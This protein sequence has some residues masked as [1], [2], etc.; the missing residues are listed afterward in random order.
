MT[1]RWLGSGLFLATLATLLLETLD[2]RLLSVL[3]WYHLSF[4]AVSLAM[5]GMA[6]GAVFVFLHPALFSTDRAPVTVAR[7]AFWF[8]ASIPASHLATLAIPFLPLSSVSVM[9]VLSV[10]VATLV[11]AVPFALSGVLVTAALTR[12]GGRIGRLYALDLVGAALGC[13][14]VI[15]LLELSNIS[16]A[17]LMAGAAAA[18]SAF[19]LAR[20][21]RVPGRLQSAVLLV[22]LATVSVVN[23]SAHPFIEVLY[24]KNQQLWLTNK[25]N[26]ITAWNSHSYVLVQGPGEQKPFLWGPGVGGDRFR[27][28]LAWLVIDGEAG[29]P[30]TEWDGRPESLEW[31]SYD[32]TT[33]PYFLRRGDV[34]VIGV[35][36]GRDILAALWGRNTSILGVDVNQIMINLLTGSHRD[37]ARIATQPQVTLVHD[38]GRAQ[39]TRTDKRFDVIQMSLVDTW[40]STGAGAFSL[41]EN[42]LYTLDAWRVFLERLKPGGVLSVSR[43]FDPSNVSE[44]SRLLSLGVATLIDRH[45]EN[46]QDH[47]LLVSRERVATLMLSNAPF[48]EADRS[49]LMPVVDSR[50]FHVLASPWTG[51]TTG[52]LARIAASRTRP[53][54]QAAIADPLFD[55][56]PP[57]DARPYYFNMLKPRAIWA[58]SLPRGGTL[59][60]NL[61]ATLMLL[62]LLGVT[63]LLVILIVVWPLIKAGRPPLPIG[64]FVTTMAY[65][66]AIGFAYMLIQIGLLQRFSVYLGHPTYTL[67]IVLFSMLLFTGLGSLVSARVLSRRAMLMVPVAIAALLLVT[68]LVLP[69]VLAATITAGLP[70]R[71]AVVLLFAA[72]LSLGL[73]MCFPFGVRLTQGAPAMVAWGW[74]V[75]GA[76]GVLASIIAVALSIWITIDA[77]FWTAAALYLAVTVPMSRMGRRP[78]L[79]AAA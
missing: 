51:A 77:N 60:G 29:T 34:A 52:L 4:F 39:L 56:S 25:L 78:S 24:P 44:T 71:T 13:V 70:A 57:T 62:V 17:I 79:A 7:V 61:R 75:N 35:G 33:L 54:L 42:G 11:L 55:Y 45:V 68:A 65:F 27:T 76:F 12:C 74:G 50:E 2:A 36:G 28:K 53:E 18:A 21:A 15:P 5:L 23:S 9:E 31:V 58:S 46:P 66:A 19:C 40:A 6:A 22:A 14:L 43:W 49:R 8:A 48:T 67:A 37:F 26:V 47:L 64:E 16:S 20:H 73:G 32:V 41:S 1:S 72:P 3:T 63:T 38:D 10:C 59:G 30:I 69:G